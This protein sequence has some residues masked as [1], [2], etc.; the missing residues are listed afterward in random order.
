MNNF[1]FLRGSRSTLKKK[2]LDY[3][4]THFEDEDIWLIDSLQLFDPYRLSRTNIEKTRHLLHSLHI[5]R[6]FTFYQL[7]DKIFSLTKLSLEESS[8]VIVSSMNCFD[9]EVNT[10]RRDILHE[11]LYHVL[12]DIQERSHCTILAGV[13]EW[14]EQSNRSDTRLKHSFKS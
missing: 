13:E 12:E 10:D 1:I 14:D 9:E 8:T 11:T 4:I 6:P 2:I 7:R 5:A 3:C